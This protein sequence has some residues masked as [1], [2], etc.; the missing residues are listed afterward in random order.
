LISTDF[1][2]GDVKLRLK[3]AAQIVG[4]TPTSTFEVASPS[5]SS[6]E[7]API[8][9]GNSSIQVDNP[10]ITLTLAQENFVASSTGSENVLSTSS[11]GIKV[12]L[13]T[14]D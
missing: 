4:I 9:L 2:T 7:S 6:S 3:S 8:I 10:N 12:Q 13:V 1:G 5:N 14:E 11:E